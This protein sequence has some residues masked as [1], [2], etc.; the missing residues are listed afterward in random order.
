MS[1]INVKN[2]SH[3]FG[4]RVIFENVSFRLLKGEHVGLVGANGEGKSTFMNIVTGALQPDEG[5]VEWSK[6]VR[7]GYLDQ[8][9]VLQKGQTIR[10]VLSSAFQYL[11]DIE[12][13]IN[14]LYL[15]M[16]D[17][18]PEE[19]DQLLEEVGELQDILEQ[20]DFYQI[21]S[22]VEEIGRGL[23]L[24]E[25]GFERDVED[26]SGGQRT[27]V[28]LAKLLL[29]KPEILMLDEPTNYLDEE[30]IAWLKQ[31]LL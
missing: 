24:H 20:S 18:T 17:V 6:K 1:I 4:E 31:Y 9:A 10:D 5:K 3:G 25:I 26:L 13:E 29:T 28:L 11:F 12:A 2:L 15:K 30:H 22:K 7:V 14:E 8:H 27:K 23:G 16:G 21:N 19:M